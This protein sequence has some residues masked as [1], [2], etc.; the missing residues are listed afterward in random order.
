MAASALDGE[1]ARSEQ[2]QRQADEA[3]RAAQAA[4]VARAD[5]EL[6]LRTLQLASAARDA[7]AEAAAAQLRRV[8]ELE[9]RATELHKALHAKVSQV[10]RVRACGGF[11]SSRCGGAVRRTRNS[12]KCFKS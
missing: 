12:A 3:E 5:T 7:E 10:W 9:A 11:S 6:Q 8:P 4:A 2:L 1:R